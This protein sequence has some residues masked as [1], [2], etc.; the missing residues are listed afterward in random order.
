[1]AKLYKKPGA[2]LITVI[3]VLLGGAITGLFLLPKG[4]RV[5]KDGYQVVYTI[6]GKVL[7]GKLQNTDGNY[8]VLKE[9]YEAQYAVP[10]T[11][12]EAPKDQ[13]LSTTLVKVSKQKYGPEDVMSINRDQVQ[14]WQNL[15]SDSKVVKAIENKQ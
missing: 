4:E 2:L 9:P 1:M 15:R 12:N 10:A 13:Q 14:F 6:S 3:L 5:N 7:F 8:L 11:S